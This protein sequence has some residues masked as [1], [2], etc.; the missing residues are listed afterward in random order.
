MFFI[1]PGLSPFNN[2]RFSNT[3][4][5]VERPRLFVSFVLIYP[6]I[7]YR[8]IVSSALRHIVGSLLSHILSWTSL[9][10]SY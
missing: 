9:R 10:D 2:W 6:T 1:I 3:D 7:H 8:L 5:R 4:V